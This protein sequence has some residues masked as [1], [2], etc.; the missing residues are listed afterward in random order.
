MKSPQYFLFFPH[1]TGLIMDVILRVFFLAYLLSIL[2]IL[3]NRV[4]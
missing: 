3:L 4:F 2:K 1:I